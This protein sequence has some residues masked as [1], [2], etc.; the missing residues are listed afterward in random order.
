MPS[1]RIITGDW[2][3]G[4]E[5][6]LIEAVQSALL[7][8]IKIPDWDRDIVVELCDSHRRIVPTGRSEQFTRIESKLFSGRS[9]EAKRRLYRSI[10][11][12]LAALG[13]PKDEIKIILVEVPLENWGVRGG[14]AASEIDLGFKVDV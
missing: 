9:L 13:V 10:V 3:R 4:R 11:Q 14:L 6:E 12:N 1:T 5:M 7:A 2:A 8:A